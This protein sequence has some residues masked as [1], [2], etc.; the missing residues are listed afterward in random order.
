MN[1]KKLLLVL[2]TAMTCS[3]KG[4]VNL[5]RGSLDYGI[6]VFS[7]A[8]NQSKLSLNL[9][10]SYSSGNG[11][12]VDDVSSCVGTGWNLSGLGYIARLTRGLPDDQAERPGAI[13]DTSKYPP[14]Y[15][16]NGKPVSEGCP[17]ALNNY[18]IFQ[19][20]GVKYQDHNITLADKELD[21]FVYNFNGRTGQFV[22]DKWGNAVVLNDN[23]LKID[24]FH[25]FAPSSVRTTIDKF[26]VTLENGLLYEFAVRENTKVYRYEKTGGAPQEING[27]WVGIYTVKSID[28]AENETPYVTTNWYLSKITDSKASRSVL[29]DYEYQVYDA[30]SSKTIQYNAMYPDN[31]AGTLTQPAKALNIRQNRSTVKHPEIKKITCPTGETI[32]FGYAHTRYDMAGVKSLTSITQK[33]KD[34]VIVSRCG[35][36]QEYF[37]KN[38]IKMPVGDEGKWSRLC[39]KSVE[40]T[41]RS[42][43]D[44]TNPYQFDYYTGSNNTDDFVPPYY[45]HAKDPWGY[46]N[47]DYSG[48]AT[49]RLLGLVSEDFPFY[50]TMA[51]YNSPEINTPISSTPD[52]A[53]NAKTGYARNGLLKQVSGPLGGK[54]VY[55]YEQNTYRDNTTNSRDA[56]VV[57]GVHLSKI[58]QKGAANGAD[59]ITSY[60][61]TDDNGVSSLWGVELPHNRTAMEGY[62]EPE[63]KTYFPTMG[64]KYTYKY[65][66]NV[67]ELAH[68]NS[69]VLNSA[70]EFA[71]KIWNFYGLYKKTLFY[72]NFLTTLKFDWGSW[73]ALVIGDIITCTMDYSR[74][75]FNNTH[76]TDIINYGNTLPMQF[77]QVKVKTISSTGMNTGYTDHTFTTDADFPLLI[78]SGNYVYPYTNKQRGF[79]WIYGLPK[80]VRVYD[81]NNHIVAT[82]ENQFTLIGRDITDDKTLSCNC[83]PFYSRSMRS[84]EWVGLANVLA[85]TKTDVPGKLSVDFYNIKTGRAE[86]LSSIQKTYDASGAVLLTTTSHTYNPNN[87]LPATTSSTDSRSRTVT[88][89]SYYIEDYDLS[90]PA[91]SILLQMRNNNLVNTPVSSETWQTKPGGQP[92]LLSASA[93]EYGLAPNGDYR[94]LKT[95]SLQTDASVPLATIGN[96]DPAHLVRNSSLIVPVSETI[97]DSKGLPVQTNDLQGDRSGCTLYDYDSRYAVAT[98]SNA[99]ITEVAYTSFEADGTGGW[100]FYAPAIMDY[101]SPTGNRCMNL[102][103]GQRPV[104]TSIAIA[105]PS[106]V[107][108]WA[109]T[110]NFTTNMG[111][112]VITGPTVNGWTYYQYA[113]AAGA[114]APVISP[115]AGADCLLDEL[116]LY[117]ATARM[118]TVTYTPNVGKTSECDA[119]NRIRYYRYDG[120]NRLTKL[121]DEKGNV[122][123]TYEYHFKQN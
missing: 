89:K 11:L 44:K 81:N 88:T 12:K 43:T 52:F 2:L 76:T 104:T 42:E 38:T 90:N 105:K 111:N 57:G 73:A 115:V 99:A 70:L 75:S 26:V 31:Y 58:I 106:I 83:V 80:K 13:T 82:T 121:L 118:A 95:Y 35:L 15:L 66:G 48:T 61:Y 25:S 78:T 119:N 110:T 24:F 53:A 84:D 39:L 1:Q 34:N 67:Q 5:Q 30:F 65:P 40:F 116:R 29:L 9:Q 47:G 8:D 16:Y 62:F 68:D 92:E 109:T 21:Y 3:V 94:P 22:I 120:L 96:F 98:V 122:L 10:L 17:Y 51:L 7:F 72:Y 20:K 93:T 112:A 114:A 41:G 107:S 28:L 55:E 32:E 59:I 97:Y 85:F 56:N 36:K 87:Y 63:Q 91:N 64:C 54:T 49:N 14:G 100:S 108:F 113:L 123:K 71:Q 74:P 50:I 37:V 23:R 46:Y 6:P 86:L 60:D 101:V 117:P 69:T 79:N 4:Q 103:A 102:R 77:A 27:K 45:F 19:D 33:G 18:P